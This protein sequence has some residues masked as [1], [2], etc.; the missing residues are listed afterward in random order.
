MY[1]L[2]KRVQQ[3]LMSARKLDGAPDLLLCPVVED[4]MHLVTAVLPYEGVLLGLTILLYP[5]LV[6]CTATST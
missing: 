4:G 5:I 1:W 2:F 6:H 3:H